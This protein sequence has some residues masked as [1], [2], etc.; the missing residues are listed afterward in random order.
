MT[1]EEQKV[2]SLSSFEKEQEITCAT[3]GPVFAKSF[4]L[5]DESGWSNPRCGFCAKELAD[6][7]EL[8]AEKRRMLDDADR[9]RRVIERNLGTSG[10]PERFKHHSFSSFIAGNDAQRVKLESCRD[11]AQNFDE[12]LRQGRC[13]ILCGGTGTGKTHLSCAIANYIIQNKYKSA[14]F[15]KVIKAVRMVKETYGRKEKSEQEAINFF[16]IPDLLI[17]DEVGVQFG[18]DTEE[19]ILFEILNERYENMKPTILISNK[20][21]GELKEFVGPRVMDRFKE[22]GGKI[23][24]FDWES[25]RSS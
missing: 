13:L 24:K 16:V 5:G 23:L 18:S 20:Q 11:Y 10:I 17:L 7:A 2:S 4:F 8:N 12:A 22:N 9:K 19:M 3:H 21:P 15:M 14:V 1:Q 25:H 6:T